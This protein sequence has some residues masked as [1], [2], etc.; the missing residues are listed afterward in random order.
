MAGIDKT[1]TSSWDDYVA[2]IEWI[3]KNNKTYKFEWT[4]GDKA[5]VSD[6]L[7]EYKQE[8]F[9]GRVWP[10]LNT[11]YVADKHLIR[12][13]PLQFVQDRMKE[14]YGEEEYLRIK[15]MYKKDKRR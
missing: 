5:S 9:D 4:G 1:Y 8:D 12:K 11:P 15:S 13:C 2:L 6:C 14:V 10:V 7:Y 3:S